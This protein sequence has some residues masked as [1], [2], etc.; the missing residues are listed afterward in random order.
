M[1]LNFFT[2]STIAFRS[3]MI[4]S[5]IANNGLESYICFHRIQANNNNDDKK[6][7]SSRLV[8]KR[9]PVLVVLLM[10]LQVSA[11]AVVLVIQNLILSD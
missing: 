1:E 4:N 5:S 6:N 9:Q 3:K 11:H 7:R 10:K 8:I 2:H